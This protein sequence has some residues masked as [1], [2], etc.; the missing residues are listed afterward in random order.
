MTIARKISSM[1]EFSCNHFDE[2]PLPQQKL[3]NPFDASI[4]TIARHPSFF[5][6]TPSCDASFPLL[7]K[8]PFRFLTKQQPHEMLHLKITKVLVPP[9]L[10]VCFEKI[11]TQ[12]YESK[13]IKG[14][15]GRMKIGILQLEKSHREFTAI[16]IQSCIDMYRR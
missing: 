7:N 1:F 9:L 13:L 8:D 11:K 6:Y 10:L 5:G 3:M 16:L 2:Y 15:Y 14:L 12:R 4:S